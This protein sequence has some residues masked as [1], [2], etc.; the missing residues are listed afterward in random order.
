VRR[1]AS[2]LAVGSGGFLVDLTCL[3]IGLEILGLAPVPARLAAFCV[4]LL[5]TYSLNRSI[6]FADRETA[7]AKRLGLYA[8]ASVLSG[9]AN[10]AVY[11]ALLQVLPETR[12]APYIAMP[13]GVGVG[14]IA[15]FTL[16]NF[17][18]FRAAR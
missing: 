2:F 18:V 15:N 16:Y 4:A 1:I 12:M 3:W 7:G 6:T 9:A 10:I 13:I 14:L 11:A 17:A 8:L 5:F